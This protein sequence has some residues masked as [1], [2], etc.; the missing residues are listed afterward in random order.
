M[1]QELPEK[2]TQRNEAIAK[3]R[4][5]II[6]E[7]AFETITKGLGLEIQIPTNDPDFV[8]IDAGDEKLVEGIRF[9][10]KREIDL[11]ELA[12]GLA[13]GDYVFSSGTANAFGIDLEPVFDCV[14]ESN[15]T[16]LWTDDEVNSE[17]AAG[18]PNNYSFERVFMEERAFRVKRSDGKVIKSPSYKAADIQSIIAAQSK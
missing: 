13:D 3:F 14:H 11:V 7:E 10:K 9:Q 8:Y 12:D 16:K 4:A 2:P 15:M 17:L 6:L 5:K 1:G 18:N